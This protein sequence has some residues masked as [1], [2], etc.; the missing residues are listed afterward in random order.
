M[1][2]LHAL[3]FCITLLTSERSFHARQNLFPYPRDLY[4][5]R[6]IRP[7]TPI[8]DMPRPLLHRQGH[9]TFDPSWGRGFGR[10]GFGNRIGPERSPCSCGDR[11]EFATL[12]QRSTDVHI[13]GRSTER[14][15][16]RQQAR[17]ISSF[18]TACLLSFPATNIFI[19]NFRFS[20]KKARKILNL[21]LH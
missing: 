19:N 3:R 1:S 12:P 9:E 15:C 17:S 2:W 16:A 5:K 18:L 14:N 21:F 6:D 13:Q 4:P 7:T 20:I 11:Y 10:H 8:L